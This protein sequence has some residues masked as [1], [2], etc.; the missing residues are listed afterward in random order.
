[1]AVPTD[2]KT[3]AFNARLFQGIPPGEQLAVQSYLLAVLAGFDTTTPAA[4]AAI[5][6]AACL[7][8]CIPKGEQLAVSN[9]L[10]AQL[11]S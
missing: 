1:M 2:P 5:Y 3:L 4:V 8:T 11:L 6:K 10:L 7:F 9:Y